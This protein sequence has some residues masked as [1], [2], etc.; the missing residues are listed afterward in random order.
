[1]AGLCSIVMVYPKLITDILGKPN[2]E[3]SNV[4]PI[5]QTAMRITAMGIIFDAF[6][7]AMVQT[8]RSLDDHVM[9]M[10]VSIGA[11]WAGVGIAAVL[12]L[13]TDLGIYGLAIGYVF[14]NVFSS[15]PLGWRFY[16]KTELGALAALNSAPA[17]HT[18]TENAHVWCC[19]VGSSGRS[20]S[21]Q[22]HLL[23]NT[24]SQE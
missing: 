1:M 18:P 8:L 13:A 4:I 16:S 24:G 7:N 15:V 21:V 11:L 23:S 3:G 10:E 9:P 5:A 20:D 22:A 19:P 6:C 2:A 17:R 12:A 14:G